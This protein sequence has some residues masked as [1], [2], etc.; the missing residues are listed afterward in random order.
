MPLNPANNEFF[1]I[2]AMSGPIDD[3]NKVFTVPDNY[4]DIRVLLNGVLYHPDSPRFGYTATA[5]TN[6][7]IT[8][9][10][11]LV[12][13]CLEA[14]FIKYDCPPELIPLFHSIAV[15]G[16]DNGTI[17]VQG[18]VA[19]AAVF[20]LVPGLRVD[21]LTPSISVGDLRP[22]TVSVN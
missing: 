8:D 6:V 19:R 7:I 13:D 9:Y 16:I 18:L 22:I 10:T 4:G 21:D 3:L 11:P 20:S 12:G 15:N 1:N 2:T 17:S 5:G 14:V